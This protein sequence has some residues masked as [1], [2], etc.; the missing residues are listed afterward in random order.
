MQH[1]M[2]RRHSPL[3]RDLQR[4]RRLSAGVPGDV[5]LGADV[6]GV[7]GEDSAVLAAQDPG[8][9]GLVRVVGVVGPVRVRER[10]VRE[11]GEEDD[12]SN[13]INQHMY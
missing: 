11:A 4:N 3:Q 13:H 7:E 10:D 1:P 12:P 2:L 5:A 6:R 9:V 8:F